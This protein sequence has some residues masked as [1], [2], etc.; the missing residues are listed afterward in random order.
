MDHLRRQERW[1]S[2]CSSSSEEQEE[3]RLSE[4]RG[5]RSLEGERRRSLTQ[6]ELNAH[7]KEAQG[8]WA[9]TGYNQAV[10]EG[11]E[12]QQD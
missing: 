8:S 12:G 5:S 11:G 9:S 2:L 7:K 4:G 3:G 1:K 6:P 10:G